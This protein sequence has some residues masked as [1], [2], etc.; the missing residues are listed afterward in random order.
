MKAEGT[1]RRGGRGLDYLSREVAMERRHS[2]LTAELRGVVLAVAA[3]LGERISVDLIATA[4]N[5]LVERLYAWHAKPMAE[6]ADAL[7]ALDWSSSAC[8]ACGQRH[9]EFS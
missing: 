3:R 7:S 2:K 1:S 5:A 4:A 8:P 6:G 9:R